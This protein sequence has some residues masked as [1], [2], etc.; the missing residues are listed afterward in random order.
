MTSNVIKTNMASDKQ[1]VCGLPNSLS[2]TP[3]VISPTHQ[4]CQRLLTAYV[5]L[6]CSIDVIDDA[7]EITHCPFFY[8]SVVPPVPLANYAW[9]IV[10]W[11]GYGAVGLRYG[12]ALLSRYV[13]VT[14]HVPTPLTAHRLIAACIVVGMKANCD[15]FI[16]NDYMAPI[17]GVSL[18]ELNRLERTLLI[19][20]E[21]R[22]LPTADEFHMTP[23]ALCA[24]VAPSRTTSRQVASDALHAA[25]FASPGHG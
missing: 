16:R 21:F 22:A 15:L 1:P 3:R 25:F 24:L 20:L 10:S 18:K 14:G 6:Q 11:A 7:D 23:R 13:Q 19:A 12:L 8:S 4:E 5:S 9:R 2:T 17:V